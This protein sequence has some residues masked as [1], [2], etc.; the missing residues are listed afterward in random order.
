MKGIPQ[1]SKTS[2]P[3]SLTA[4][5][6]KVLGSGKSGLAVL[7]DIVHFNTFI[8]THFSILRHSTIENYQWQSQ[9][10]LGH[11]PPNTNNQGPT[12]LLSPPTAKAVS[13]RSHLAPQAEVNFLSSFRAQQMDQGPAGLTVGP[14]WMNQDLTVRIRT[15]RD[16]SGP[17]RTN[18]GPAGHIRVPQD[19]SGPLRTNQSL[20]D[21][22]GRIKA[23]GALLQVPCSRSRGAWLLGTNQGPA[24]RIRVLQDESGPRKT[25]QS[26]ARRKS[27]P[28]RTNQSLLDESGPPAQD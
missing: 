13:P 21:E 3:V 28:H 20:L 17:R 18:Q 4:I 8:L 19:V 15:L 23:P 1:Q 2:R 10:H 6:C 27:G 9:G 16:K 24:R 12:Y 7:G 22:S 11:D 25:N 5:P 26:P 14:Y